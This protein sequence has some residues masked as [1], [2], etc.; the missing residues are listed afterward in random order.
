MT[1]R[2]SSTVLAVLLCSC[3]ISAAAA[4]G[5]GSRDDFQ[6]IYPGNNAYHQPFVEFRERNPGGNSLT[7]HAFVALGYHLD[8]GITAYYAIAGYYRKEVPGQNSMIG[9]VQ[10]VIGSPGDVS[11]RF[12][13]WR[14]DNVLRYSITEGQ[15]RRI[16]M[17]INSAELN[18]GTFTA[19]QNNCVR[20][21]NDV[22]NV[23]VQDF[24]CWGPPSF[25]G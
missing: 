20:F 7:G 6:L 17:I 9:H 5:A 23:L 13:D 2:L 19:L 12:D 15:A 11:Y 8:N 3:V 25:L 18:P 10:A 16:E 22:A 24:L 4:L 1:I 14:T 21:M